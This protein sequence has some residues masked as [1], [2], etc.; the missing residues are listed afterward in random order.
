VPLTPAS[1][2]GSYEILAP[3]GT[4]GMGEVYQA[5]D[6]R[7][8]RQV[9]IKV[10]PDNL[11]SS[12]DR[13]ARFEREAKTVA[14]LNH[15]NIVV[16]H[17]IEEAEGTRF[18]TMEL[19]EGRSLDHAI[20]PGGL[21][22]PRVIEIG[23][24]LADAL[25]A[26]HEKRVVH[27]DLKPANVM[28]TRDGRVKVLDFGLAKL[29]EE[30]SGG[31]QELTS[32]PTAAG[33]PGDA[34]ST[35]GMVVGTV[36]YMSPE[37]VN[38]EV[39]DARTDLFSLGV[40]LYEMATGERPFRGRTSAEMI[41]SILRDDPKPV[42]EVRG[43]VPH[44]LAR[45]LDHCLQKDRE[46]RF[47]TAKDVRNELHALRREVESGGTA[48][49]AARATT[50]TASAPAMQAGRGK[51]L[52]V[53]IAA[54]VVAAILAVVVFRSRVGQAPSSPGGAASSDS[55]SIA[56][57]PFLDMSQAK[58][59]EYFSDGIAEELLNLLA[60]IQE[61]K[62]A[63]RTSSFSFKGK[64]VEVPEIAR[65]L[66]VAHV[67]E[68]SV[69]KNGDQV[70]I[71]A[72]LIQASDGLATW[73]QTYDRRIDDIF[74]IQDEIA[75]DVVR[76]LQVKLLGPAP[77]ARTTDPQAYALYLQ[78]VELGNQFTTAGFMKSDTLLRQALAIDPRYAP[79]WHRLGANADNEGTIGV[80][81]GAE[82]AARTREAC[83]KAIAIDPEFAPAYSL[84]GEIAAT[85][86]N[87][88]DGAAK[89]LERALA[90]DP[91]SPTILGLAGTLLDLL[92]RKEEAL[93]LME[94]QVRRDPVNPA[95][96]TRLGVSQ[97]WTGR[98]DAAIATFRTL[99]NLNSGRGR[100]H[101]DYGIVLLLKGDAAGALEEM[102]Q[103]PIEAWRMIGLPMAYHALGRRADSDQ[104]LAALIAKYEKDA[105]YNIAYVYAFRGEP[106]KAFAWLDKT[107]KYGD[108][109]LSE[110][111][112][113]SFFDTIHS[114]PRW[115]PFLRRI[116]KA[117]EQ[118]AKIRFKVTL[119]KE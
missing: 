33:R 106:D 15:P 61:L 44:D 26:A 118:L 84:L 47:Q 89:N 81:S 14:G 63:A 21:P 38:G 57:L 30:D 55:M 68:G 105:P 96:L 101:E 35:A 67:L 74:K 48:I 103:E 108:P 12:P 112:V 45:I 16:L 115:L 98:L 36:P 58:D 32:A 82:A 1:R 53:G 79:A 116:G 60:R 107:V 42:S 56:V 97:R 23:I 80:L 70:R 2:L 114:D 73:S 39:L 102:K 52:W 27:R 6:P 99:L 28:L 113:E 104:A 9:A 76:E 100:T 83:Q 93:A 85:Y 91:R 87:D 95:A 77:Q 34:L 7:L 25:A 20:V 88:L 72:Q 11:A 37:Q 40:V 66:H 65:Q 41:S 86:D 109:G 43:D 50:Q 64:E 5:R 31:S 54:V 51:G 119:P 90:L 13:L 8:D 10:L 59:Q 46:S 75:A 94:A 24:A 17:S 117:P 3:L 111:A 4:G 78:A 71:T 22:I 18:L 19:V 62:V 69:R 49:R 29:T 92:G 110:I